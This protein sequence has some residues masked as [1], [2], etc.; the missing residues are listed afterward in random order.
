MGEVE[1]LVT[2]LD[3]T[4][5]ELSR[6]IHPEV[7]S[8][9][10]E[11]ERRGYP[12]LV[13]T[14]RR[15]ASAKSPLVAHG[16]TPP[17]VVLNGAQV[18][19]L[20]TGRRIYQRAFDP[21]EATSI[22]QLFLEAEIEPV[23]YVDHRE[24]EVFAGLNPATHPDHLSQFGAGLARGELSEIVS[25]YPIL[26]FAVVSL[27]PEVAESIFAQLYE[28]ASAHLMAERGYSGGSTITVSPKNH[29]KWDGVIAYCADLGA[30]PSRI[31]AI[32]DGPNDLEL[33]EGARVAVAPVDADPLVLAK[34][35]HV[36]P[37]AK[38]AG[39]AALLD[40]LP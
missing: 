25:S 24:I 28:L 9:W 11:I 30:D 7:V 32:G 23:V 33:L 3:G 5:W 40:L 15:L 1:M 17:A 21:E 22:L 13:A 31:L 26:H 10:T 19:D 35:N 2:D 6:F 27:P 12:I 4:L 37:A 20:A 29:S 39:W 14:G 16:L 36:V 34:A 38:E 8:A 18:V